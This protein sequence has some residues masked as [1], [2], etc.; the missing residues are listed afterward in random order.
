MHEV[1]AQ[2]G[3]AQPAGVARLADNGRRRPVVP[4]VALDQMAGCERGHERQ[5]AG[6]H[7]PAHDPRQLVGVLAGPLRV[8]A[9]DAQHLQAGRLGRQHGAAADRADLDG[10]HRAGDVQVVA[11]LA[12]GLHQRHA[13]AAADVLGRVLAGGDVDG[14][15]DVGGVRVEAADAA[16][17]RR[18]DHVLGDVDVHERLDARF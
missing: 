16:G 18:A 7:G 3:G 10:R 4:H 14:R 5:L 8:G 6:Q 2:R 12:P 1:V 17:Y 11:R 15:Q 13:V 9:P